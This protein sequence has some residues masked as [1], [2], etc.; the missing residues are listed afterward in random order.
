MVIAL[1][2][3]LNWRVAFYELMISTS[4]SMDDVVEVINIRLWLKRIRRSR[5]HDLNVMFNPVFGRDG[6]SAMF[7]QAYNDSIVTVSSHGILV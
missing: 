6:A 2:E 1:D 5:R 4:D 7:Q 3:R